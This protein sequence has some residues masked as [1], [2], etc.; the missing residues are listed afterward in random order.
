M[1]T[2]TS[3]KDP[4]RIIAFNGHCNLPLSKF[5]VHPFC[6][7]AKRSIADAIFAA[8]DEGENSF[9]CCLALGADTL[10]SEGRCGYVMKLILAISSVHPFPY[11]DRETAGTAQTIFYALQCSISVSLKQ[12]QSDFERKGGQLPPHPFARPAF[13]FSRKPRWSK[14]RNPES[15]ATT[16]LP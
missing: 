16:Q 5:E 15:W 13:C 1:I 11:D 12:T 7:D 8:H 4:S 14:T 9:I 2:I 3:Y 10:F 6:A